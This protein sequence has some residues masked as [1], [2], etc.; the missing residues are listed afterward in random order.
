MVFLHF[1]TAVLLIGLGTALF[2]VFLYMRAIGS[3]VAVEESVWIWGIEV[4]LFL[5]CIVIGVISAVSLV[6]NKKREG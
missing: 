3:F 5:V 1:V 2:S 6:S 4:G